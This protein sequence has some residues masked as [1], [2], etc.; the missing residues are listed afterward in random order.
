[1][2]FTV[3]C[4]LCFN[5]IARFFENKHIWNTNETHEQNLVLF[6][7]LEKLTALFSVNTFH[8][9]TLQELTDED[10]TFIGFNC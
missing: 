4:V 5:C 3:N 9:H 2:F 7:T 10:C 8:I 1:M 6:I